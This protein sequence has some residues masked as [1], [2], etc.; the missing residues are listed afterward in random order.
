MY[1]HLFLIKR[2]KEEQFLGKKSEG[3]CSMC[4]K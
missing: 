1:D 2:G 3:Y 4:Q